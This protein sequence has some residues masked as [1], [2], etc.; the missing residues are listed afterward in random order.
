MNRFDIV[1]D[2]KANIK[3]LEKEIDN[4]LTRYHKGEISAFICVSI[5]KGLKD[6]IESVNNILRMYEWS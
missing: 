4:T 6:R 1:E 2:Y 5:E 3:E